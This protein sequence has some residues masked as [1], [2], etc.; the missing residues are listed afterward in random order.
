[1]KKT[2]LACQTIT[3]GD[4]QNEDF[5][6]VFRE[7]KAAGFEGVEIGWRRLAN[8]TAAEL[9]KLLK[10]AELELVGVHMGGNLKDAGQAKGEWGALDA[11]IKYLNEAGAELLMFSGLRYSNDKQLNADVAVLMEASERCASQGVNFLYHNHDWEFKNG[12]EAFDALLESSIKFCPDLG[13]IYKAGESIPVVL[14]EI[15][16]RIGAVHFKDF[17]NQSQEKDEWLNPVVLGTGKASLT[18]GA[19][20]MLENEN[21]PL[22]WIAEQDFADIPAGE[23]ARQNAAFLNLNIK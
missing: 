17:K 20:W 2:K 15:K 14:D 7:I 6:K 18:D 13:W 1:M 12:R 9:K 4:N 10:E 23:A 3:W 22:W 19:K 16:G 8:T 21:I 5:A 11:A